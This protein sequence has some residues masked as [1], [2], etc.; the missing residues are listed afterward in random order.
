MR[1]VQRT[2]VPQKARGKIQLLPLDNQGRGL[3]L[4][5]GNVGPVQFTGT[6]GFGL[7]HTRRGLTPAQ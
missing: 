2:E 4:Q 5:L 3:H 7:P 6:L 1:R